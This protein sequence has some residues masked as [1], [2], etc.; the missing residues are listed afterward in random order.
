[1]ELEA[2]ASP[3]ASNPAVPGD[4]THGYNLRPRSG[5]ALKTTYK[6]D[7]MVSDEFSGYA[8]AMRRLDDQ[9]VF[10]PTSGKVTQ[11]VYLTYAT[12]KDYEIR[13]VDIKTAF[14]NAELDEP[15]Y[16]QIPDGLKGEELHG[17]SHLVLKLN[18]SLYG[19]K[20]APRLWFLH[21]INMLTTHLGFYS[22]ARTL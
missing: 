14:L 18:K 1:M 17:N 4:P 16:I 12:L 3:P 22:L 5:K 6:D 19:M 9:E 10:A 15:I 13:Q 8:N 11:R 2:P 21:L 7:W 20:Q